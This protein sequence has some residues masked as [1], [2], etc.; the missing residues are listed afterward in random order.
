MS[1]ILQKK[2]AGATLPALQQ[3]FDNGSD[4]DK[5]SF[6][7]SMGLYHPGAVSLADPKYGIKWDGVTDC[8]TGVEDALS[9]AYAKGG[10]LLVPPAPSSAP[11]P[12]IIDSIN[13]PY[14]RMTIF[15]YNQLSFNTGV[16]GRSSAFKLKSSARAAYVF[17]MAGGN[18]NA[19]DVTAQNITMRGIQLDGNSANQTSGVHGIWMAPAT[20]GE[21]ALI[22]VDHCYIHHCTGDA[23]RSDINNGASRRASRITDCE[24]YAC[25]NGV[26]MFSSDGW[27]DRCNIGAMTED[28][29]QIR[30]WTTRVTNN[31]IWDNRNGIHCRIGEASLAVISGNGVDR[32]RYSG[33]IANGSGTVVSSNIL[34]ANSRGEIGDPGVTVDQ[35]ALNPHISVT[36]SGPVVVGN[37][38]RDNGPAGG[39]LCSYDIFVASGV[40]AN[41]GSNAGNGRGNS[42]V[43]GHL[44]LGAGASN[45]GGQEPRQD[46]FLLGG[47]TVADSSTTTAYTLTTLHLASKVIIR[48]GAP[49]SSVT[50]T[51][52][53]AAQIISSYAAAA[54]SSPV[55][56]VRIIRIVNTMS[57]AVTV[58][59]S[60]G[61]T[62]SGSTVL[63]ALTWRE[64]AISI[65]SGTTV[66]F[67]GVGSGTV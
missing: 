35:N 40:A 16:Y 2:L 17:C 25:L 6:Q 12:I 44:G 31:N 14:R 37:S 24:L 22:E 15:G 41:I 53:T 9:D 13:I 26:Q 3:V 29:V 7:A 62:I 55:Q 19:G 18:V 49:A 51:T 5:A 52:P 59:A 33:I 4:S 66:T 30:N 48:S 38:F 21:D 50:D 8:T 23:I 47:V 10:V 11:Y 45:T 56:A 43:Y 63:A 28:G 57:Q 67:T 34:H 61:V 46:G 39:N 58:S 65:T 60:A 36:G 27:I 1:D 20:I 64:Y 32:N 42:N 54:I